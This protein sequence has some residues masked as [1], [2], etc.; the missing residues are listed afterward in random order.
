MNEALTIVKRKG[1]DPK[2]VL[3][4]FTATLFPSPIYKS[5]RNRLLE[6]NIT[7]LQNRIPIKDIDILKK[8]AELMGSSTPISNTLSELL[9][10]ESKEK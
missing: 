10:S 9:E 4:M 5:Y 8:A 6:G 2:S 7:F 3:D 1:F